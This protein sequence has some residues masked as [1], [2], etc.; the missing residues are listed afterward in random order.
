MAV[1]VIP[2]PPPNTVWIY[3]RDC[4][5]TLARAVIV[6]ALVAG[7]GDGNDDD[8]DDVIW[9]LIAG[10][11]YL[12]EVRAEWEDCACGWVCET[13][14]KEIK[15]NFRVTGEVYY[16]IH[17][18]G[19]D[20]TEITHVPALKLSFAAPVATGGRC[21]CVFGPNLLSFIVCRRTSFLCL[22]G[23]SNRSL[24]ALAQS[25]KKQHG[26]SSHTGGLKSESAALKA[27]CDF[28]GKVATDTGVIIL[29]MQ[30]SSEGHRLDHHCVASFSDR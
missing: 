23:H 24:A 11:Y 18:T 29:Q 16:L 22:F 10:G 30:L 6:N 17:T 9:V 14:G 15:M 26:A 1:Q 13:S 21:R 2:P 20:V 27:A 28:S 5:T 25:G 3:G 7:A 12:S 19:S 8:Y 4:A